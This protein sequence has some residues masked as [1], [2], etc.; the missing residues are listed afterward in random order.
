MIAL[1]REFFTLLCPADTIAE[2]IGLA[3]PDRK[4]E[5]EATSMIPGS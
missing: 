5:I 4:I 2:A 1:R 3:Q